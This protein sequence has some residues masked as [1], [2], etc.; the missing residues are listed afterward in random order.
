MGIRIKGKRIG[1]PVFPAPLAGITEITDVPF[2]NPVSESGARMI[3][4]NMGCPARRVVNGDSGSA[5]MRDPET[6]LRLLPGALQP[7]PAQR[8]A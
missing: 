3:D 7:A 6:V 2:G 4:I 5:Q 8:A 1:P